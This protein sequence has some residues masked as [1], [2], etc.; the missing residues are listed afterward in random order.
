MFP[1]TTLG[2]PDPS[3]WPELPFHLER[4]KSG[5]EEAQIMALSAID[6]GFRVHSSISFENVRSAINETLERSD[7]SVT[8]QASCLRTLSICDY[9]HPETRAKIYATLSSD[10]IPGEIASAI[11]SGLFFTEPKDLALFPIFAKHCCSQD[12][13]VAQKALSTLDRWLIK[14]TPDELNSVTMSLRKNNDLIGRLVYF[15]KREV[16][17]LTPCSASVLHKLGLGELLSE[18]L[19]ML[20]RI[21]PGGDLDLETLNLETLG[22]LSLSSKQHGPRLTPAQQHELNMAIKSDGIRPPQELFAKLFRSGV[23]V[24]THNVDLLSNTLQTLSRE[25]CNLRKETGLTHVALCLDT[26]MQRLEAFVTGDVAVGSLGCSFSM[27]PDAYTGQQSAEDIEAELKLLEFLRGIWGKVDIVLLDSDTT[28]EQRGELALQAK[29]G[30]VVEAV[31]TRAGSRIIM[32]GYSLQLMKQ[33][34]IAGTETSLSYTAELLEALGEG[35]VAAVLGLDELD[36]ELQGS[37]T[38]NGMDEFVNSYPPSGS[39]G[40]FVSN[41]PLADL[42]W[43]RD[44][45]IPYIDSWDAIVFRHKNDQDSSEHRVTP[46]TVKSDPLLINR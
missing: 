33:H 32:L 6:A 39:F 7:S 24:V 40:L 5:D 8:L 36:V 25:I 28:Q 3:R 42:L 18:E 9:S 27:G 29:T 23:K 26:S 43:D 44:I 35:S 19:S 41:T 34:Y 13:D 1:G 2:G 37:S 14:L 20:A 4:L 45:N 12:E 22:Q 30:S 38:G 10:D 15:T 11:L 17:G 46:G 31:N 21:G 16:V